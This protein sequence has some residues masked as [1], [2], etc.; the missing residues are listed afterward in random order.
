MAGVQ[1]MSK[2]LEDSRKFATAA[3]DVVPGAEVWLYGSYAKGCPRPGSDIDIA[4]VVPDGYY[5]DPDAWLADNKRLWEIAWD[6]NEIIEPNLR[7]DS[8]DLMRFVELAVR[9]KGIRLA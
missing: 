6:I 1:E 7:I 9:G 3:L 5:T 8:P 4:V 2:V